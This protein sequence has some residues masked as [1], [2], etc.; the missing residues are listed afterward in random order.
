MNVNHDRVLLG[1]QPAN[2]FG[3]GQSDCKVLLHS[4]A[5]LPP[6][7]LNLQNFLCREKFGLNMQ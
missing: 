5:M 3:Q 7:F 1:S 2:I 6:I 4:G